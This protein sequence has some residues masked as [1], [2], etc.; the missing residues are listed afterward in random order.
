MQ[1]Q[2][3]AITQRDQNTAQVGEVSPCLQPLR[4]FRHPLCGETPQ[5]PDSPSPRH[6]VGRFAPSLGGK[7]YTTIIIHYTTIIRSENGCAV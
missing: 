6:S 5:R 1:P 3:S 4:G 7:D 2:S